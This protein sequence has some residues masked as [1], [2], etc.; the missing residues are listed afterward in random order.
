M[1]F[2]ATPGSWVDAGSGLLMLLLGAFLLRLRPRRRANL[3][4]GAFALLF[5]VGKI[6]DNLLRNEPLAQT[7]NDTGVLI[8]GIA[9]LLLIPVAAW[10]PRPLRPAE[11]RLVAIA[12]GVVLV[13]DLVWLTFQLWP[14]GLGPAFDA[15]WFVNDLLAGSLFGGFYVAL[16]LQALRYPHLAGASAERERRNALLLSAAL[17]TFPGWVAGLA[18]GEAAQALPARL[19]AQVAA[20]GLGATGTLAVGAVAVLNNTWLVAHVL[21]AGLWARNARLP[22]HGR[23]CRNLSLLALGLPLAGMLAYPFLGPSPGDAGLNGVMRL[24]TVAILA[25]AILRHQLLDIDVK[26]RWG[27]RQST[28]AGAFIG[29]FFVVS[30]GAQTVLSSQYGPI[31]GIVA[32]GGLVFALAPLQRA[33][34]RVASAA[35]PGAKPVGAMSAEERVELYRAMARTAWEDGVLDRNERALL[36]ELRQRLGLSP[37]EAER[38]EAEALA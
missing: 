28:L 7:L 27:I 9:A 36:R 12:V 20:S 17:L 16:L 31:L 19:P 25:Y 22:G 37:D 11:R 13:D 14:P 30:E 6:L 4:L 10:V 15:H 18:L 2:L 34:E 3:A 8:E 24:I 35:V 5:G 32:T 23:G 29:V 33:A 26:V 1:S 21:L 38:I